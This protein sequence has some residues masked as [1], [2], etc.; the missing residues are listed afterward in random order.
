MCNQKPFY[1][2]GRRFDEVVS[3]KAWIEPIVYDWRDV[4]TARQSSISSNRKRE[5]EKERRD[6]T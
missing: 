1:L 4:R 6:A 5:R 3:G 2:K